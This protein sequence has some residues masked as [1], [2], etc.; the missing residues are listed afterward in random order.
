MHLAFSFGWVSDGRGVL[1]LVRYL[2]YHITFSK[3][4]TVF[5]NYNRLVYGL[6]WFIIL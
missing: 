5:R 4:D 2:P 1:F 6:F 3:R